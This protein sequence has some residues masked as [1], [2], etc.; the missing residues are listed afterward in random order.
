MRLDGWTI[1]LFVARM[2]QIMAHFQLACADCFEWLGQQKDHRFH[3]VITDPPF[4][5]VEFEEVQ[6]EKMKNGSG[7]VWRIPPKIGGHKRSPL[8]RFTVYSQE[9][10]DRLSL[11][12]EKFG[13]ALLPKVVPG[14][15][16]FIA[17]TTQLSH[18][19]FAAIAKAGFERRGEIVRLVRTL[20]GG[21]RPKNAHEEFPQVCVSPRSCWEPWGLFRAP[22][23]GRVQDNLRKWRTGG[24]KRFSDETPFL[25]VIPSE[26]TPAR[27]R[28]IA[29]HPSLKPQS[30]LRLLASHILPFDEGMVLD[31]FAGSGST[32]AACLAVD[33][34]S[35]GVEQN[36]GYYRMAQEVIPRLA[37][38]N[39]GFALA[40]EQG[41][42]EQGEQLAFVM[43]QRSGYKAS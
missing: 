39:V 19:V 6:L 15:H 26:K 9:E 4:A 38:L 27:E 42:A 12:F 41:T 16:L 22:L 20:R 31:P 35:A 33:I 18:I 13:K 28:K 11:Y 43:E 2:D 32:L 10:L 23:E 3:A 17:A 24:L 30:F 14:A 5:V 36:V 1:T 21:D 7:G 8:P 25:D 34:E 37:K 29:N 40:Q